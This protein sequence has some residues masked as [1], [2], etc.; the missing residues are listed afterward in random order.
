MDLIRTFRTRS[1][2][3][4]SYI[5]VIVNDSSSF[6][7]TLFLKHKIKTFEAFKKFANVLQNQNGYTIMSLRSDHGHKF[8]NNG[9]A[10]FCEN[11]GINYDFL[12]LRTPQRNGVIKRKIDVLKK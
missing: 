4:N 6:T 5:L 2:G 11:N 7:W 1:Y 3:G 12:T 9:F 8:K 10:K